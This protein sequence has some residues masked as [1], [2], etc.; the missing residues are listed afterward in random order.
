MTGTPDGQADAAPPGARPLPLRP[1]VGLMRELVGLKR[2]H[3]AGRDG[4]VAERLFRRA[5][6]ALCAGENP[7]DVALRET[8]AFVAA[9]RLAGFDAAYLRQ[10]G[11]PDEQVVDALGRGLDAVAGG[12]D[13][14]QASLLRARLG[15]PATDGP[16]PNFVRMLAD[17]PRAG[18]TYPGKARKVLWPFENHAEHCALVATLGVL[19]AP[20]WAAEPGSVFLCGL[21]HHLHNARM[22]DAGFAGDTLLSDLV[23]GLQQQATDQALAELD[24][25]LR[26]AVRA[27]LSDIQSLD[28]PHA[29]AFH[30]AD[31]F[32]RVLEIEWHA[33]QA[34]FTLDEALGELQLVHEGFT[35][36]F[37]NELLGEAGLLLEG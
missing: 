32:D 10:S 5:W 36:R 17:Q 20:R 18:A 15:E 7:A 9:A 24:E 37:Q 23:P 26:S 14:E 13:A 16:E 3:V 31:G 8:A 2:I 35:Q 4:S 6:R 22:P 27:A 34:A 25:P 19:L 11:V 1:L 30:A 29:R 28:T 12:L 33:R 21:A